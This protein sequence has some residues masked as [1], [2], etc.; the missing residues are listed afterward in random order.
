MDL[1]PTTT[2][3]PEPAWHRNQ[4]ARRQRARLA[5]R[6]A[7][8]GQVCDERRLAAAKSLLLSH[9]GTRGTAV[10]TMGARDRYVEWHGNGK[11]GN[12]F[13]IPGE[14]YWLCKP[15]SDKQPADGMQFWV[16]QDKAE[17]RCGKQRPDKPFRFC[18][19]QCGKATAAGHAGRTAAANAKAGGKAAAPPKAGAGGAADTQR[20]RDDQRKIAALQKEKAALQKQINDAAEA[21]KNAGGGNDDAGQDANE[22]SEEP[23]GTKEEWQVEIEEFRTA[24]AAQR[25]QLKETKSQM[26]KEQL[27]ESIEKGTD[28]IEVLQGLIQSA[29]SPQEQLAKKAAK[30]KRLFDSLPSI[31]VKMRTE[32]DAKLACLAAAD[33]HEAE[34]VRLSDLYESTSAMV[35]RLNKEATEVCHERLEQAVGAGEQMAKEIDEKLKIF[36]DPALSGDSSVTQKK[37]ELR[38]T[39][40]GMRTQWALFSQ[41]LDHLVKYVAETRDSQALEKRRKADEEAKSAAEAAKKADE[42]AK[43]AKKAEDEKKRKADEEAKAAKKA[44]DDRKKKAD[45]DARAAK[46]SEE[47]SAAVRAKSKS[48]SPTPSKGF[49]IGQ[50]GGSASSSSK[51]SLSPEVAAALAKKPSDR[52]DADTLLA[53]SAAKARRLEKTAASSTAADAEMVVDSDVNQ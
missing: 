1:A 28:R 45:E 42:E 10:A 36:D 4:R 5:L 30:A 9:H 48:R 16:P 37:D 24:V 22:S 40:E 46:K 20:N 2:T 11:N 14:Q 21:A 38:A 25:K 49:G 41:Q 44:E 8:G 17:C 13:P 7:K 39:S 53:A 12:P 51:P 33:K 15:C 23:E 34:E 3:G 26:L 27:E 31:A 50:G 43:A 6:V 35:T 47:A 18:N 19:S 29:Q 32:Q 52:T